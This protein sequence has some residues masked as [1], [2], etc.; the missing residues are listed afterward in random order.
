MTK[1]TEPTLPRVFKTA[2]FSK[3]AKKAGIT[4]KELCDAVKELIQGL[5]DADLG[6]NVYK[7]RLNENRHRSIVITKTAT[8]W[9]F[10]FLFSKA[11]RDNITDKELT[12]FKKLSKDYATLNDD[13]VSIQLVNKDLME[14]CNDCPKKI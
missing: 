1:I 13:A 5:W 8:Y 7:K 11:E 14:I 3:N 10:T 2:W 4:D 9:F 6:G 12:G